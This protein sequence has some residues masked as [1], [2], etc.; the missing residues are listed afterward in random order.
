MHML[1]IHSV[2][3]THIYVYSYIYMNNNLDINMNTVA[4][5]SLLYIFSLY[6]PRTFRSGNNQSALFSYYLE[7]WRVF[8]E[9][10][11]LLWEHRLLEVSKLYLSITRQPTSPLFSSRHGTKILLKLRQR[12][13][14]SRRKESLL[15][16]PLHFSETC[17][18]NIWQC[19]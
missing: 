19:T 7:E 17:I 6:N 13:W 18:S 12:F 11:A 3:Y 14:H 2:Q 4:A 8:V 5:F 9:V 1:D 16:D 15:M 10:G